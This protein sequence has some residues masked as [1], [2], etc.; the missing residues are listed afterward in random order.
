MATSDNTVDT[1]ILRK[2]AAAVYLVADE[3]AASSLSDT[4]NAAANEIDDLRSQIV[5]LREE[6]SELYDA[7][8]MQES[9]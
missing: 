2:T 4:L 1:N 6:L 8:Y 9:Q 3:V 5:Q 7:H